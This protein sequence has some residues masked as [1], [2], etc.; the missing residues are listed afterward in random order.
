M[1]VPAMASP[2]GG[3][4]QRAVV[5]A[6]GIHSGSEKAKGKVSRAKDATGEGDEW[7]RTDEETL[8]LALDAKHRFFDFSRGDVAALVLA[9]GLSGGLKWAKG[10]ETYLGSKQR[11]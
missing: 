1:N 10:G 7:R 5:T 9:G 2:A 3:T 6:F 8:V 11:R 4:E